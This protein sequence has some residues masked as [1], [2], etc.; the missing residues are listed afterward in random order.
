MF[1]TRTPHRPNPIGLSVASVTKIEKHTLYLNGVDLVHGTPIFDIKPYISRYDALPTSRYPQWIAAP[2]VQR[3]GVCVEPLAEAQLRS[4]FVDDAHVDLGA[5][6][7][8]RTPRGKRSRLEF[9]ESYDELRAA[10]DDVLG[11]DT[12]SITARQAHRRGVEQRAQIAHSADVTMPKVNC[13]VLFC[14]CFL[15]RFFLFLI[16]FGLSVEVLLKLNQTI[17][18]SSCMGG[19]KKNYSSIRMTLIAAA[20]ACASMC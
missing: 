12:R 15:F 8:L 9:Y 1:A 16:C 14:F 4:L 2:P 17:I 11:N 10:I 18:F 19:Y 6:T 3:L 5:P 13:F 7:T 20:T